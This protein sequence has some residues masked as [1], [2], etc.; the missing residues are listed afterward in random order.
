MYSYSFLYKT[1]S[2]T[3]TVVVS[4]RTGNMAKAGDCSNSRKQRTAMMSK[5]VRP[6]GQEVLFTYD[7]LGRDRAAADSKQDEQDG[8]PEAGLAAPQ[9]A[10]EKFRSLLSQAAAGEPD[11]AN[12]T[13]WVF[14]DRTFR[15]AAKITTDGTYSII[16]DHLG[17]P[18]EMYNEQGE[19]VWACELDIYG[20]V[21]SIHLQG[22]RSDCPFRY[23]GQYEDEE[24]G[25]Y[26]NRF[27][28]YSPHEGMYTQQ[29]P[30]GM[31][32]NNPTLYGYVSDP[33]RNVD[34]F[35]LYSDLLDTGMGHHLMPRSIAKALGISELSQINSIAWYPNKGIGTA[36]LHKQLHR[37]LID[38]G[39]PYHGSK[40]TGTAD[41]FFN[42]AMKAY[43]DIDVKGYMKIPFTHEHLFKNLTPS[44]ALDKLRE[45]NTQGTIPCSK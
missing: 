31:A 37:N 26:Y 4:V 17:T 35:G 44:E 28:Y 33:N 13:T 19:R 39:V 41:E 14:E 23:P 6:D 27:R 18:V 3:C 21:Q 34:V 43:A 25:L 36:D 22:K 15:P 29:D 7:S 42:K 12:L 10:A 45:L 9:G 32:G 30:I 11:S 5:V 20:N 8:M 16:T 40:F 38:A 24:T 1:K 2:G